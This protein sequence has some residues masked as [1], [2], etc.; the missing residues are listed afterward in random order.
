[1]PSTPLIWLSKG[2]AT[3]ASTTSA[4]A[5]GKLAVTCT[6]G[7]TI[8]GN[9]ATGMRSNEIKPAIVVRIAMTMANRGRSTNSFEIMAR[10][11]RLGAEPGIAPLGVVGAG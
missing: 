7:G 10:Q 2:C 11:P 5:P 1:M 8:S 6:C 3:V 4:E 9:C